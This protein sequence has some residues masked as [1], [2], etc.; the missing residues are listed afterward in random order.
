MLYNVCHK[1]FVE[2][3]NL[4]NLITSY[5]I[6]NE[7]EVEDLHFHLVE[8]WESLDTYVFHEKW[9]GN[10]IS[11]IVSDTLIFKEPQ[12]IV[13]S[14]WNWG[15]TWWVQCTPEIDMSFMC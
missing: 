8:K 4:I 3:V 11:K 6:L 13:L 5:L 14:K 12:E 2:V 15:C 9:D 7:S 1:W 10:I